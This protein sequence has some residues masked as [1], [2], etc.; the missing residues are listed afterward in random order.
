MSVRLLLGYW[1]RVCLSVLTLAGSSVVTAQQVADI[2]RLVTLGGGVTEI[3]YALG[4]GDRIIGTDQSSLY[5]PEA[6]ELQSVGYY[7]KLP[8]E[9]VVSLK[10]TVILASEHAGPPEVLNQIRQLGI[11]VMTVPDSPDIESLRARV[12]AIALVLGKPDQGERLLEQLESSLRSVQE[13]PVPKLT[14][15]TVVMRGGK[16]LGAGAG[17]A[18]DVVLA[19]S[20]LHNVLEAQRSYRPLSAEVVSALAPEVIVV[21]SSTVDSMG[22]LDEVKRSPVLSMTPAV[23]NNKVIVLDDMLAQGFGL[24]FPQAVTLVHDGVLGVTN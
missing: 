15:M 1:L 21:T 9:G 6:T 7:R 13:V 17:T 20:G 18:A 8:V 5:P 12:R 23:R 2:S 3:V 16:L 22:G 11:P 4:E 10:P 14:A 19:S 24:R